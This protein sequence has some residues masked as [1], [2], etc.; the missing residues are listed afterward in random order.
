MKLYTKTGDKGTTSLYGGKRLSKDNIRIEAYGTVDELNSVLGML[1]TCA[2]TE[3]YDNL[4]EALQIELFNIGSHLAASPES[5][6]PLPTLKTELVE[7]LERSMDDM[8]DQIPK[9]RSFILPGG[10]AAASWAHLARTVCR[11]AER[12]VVTLST[13]ESVEEGI[14]IFL[15]RLSDYCFVLSRYI[16]FKEGKQEVEWKSGI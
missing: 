1:R 7:T 12:R 9:L 6:F 16:L 14:I 8:N 10:S 4:H 13:D 11:R 3:E 2:S 15:N 5:D